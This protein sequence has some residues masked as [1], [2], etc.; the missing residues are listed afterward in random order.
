MKKI[1][2][3]I[4][5]GELKTIHTDKLLPLFNKLGNASI[6]RASY[7][8]PIDGTTNWS[9]DLSL[10]GG[11]IM[12]PFTTRDEAISIEIDWLL[13]NKITFNG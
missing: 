8:E 4:L 6:K 2:L 13:K 12:G 5:N 11:P 7:V 10:V 1:K 3:C 9:V